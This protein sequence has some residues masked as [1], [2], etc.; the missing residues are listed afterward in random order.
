METMLPTIEIYVLALFLL[1]LAFL[2]YSR[3]ARVHLEDSDRLE[4]DRANLRLQ[5]I[6]RLLEAPD[7]RHLLKNRETRLYVFR[8]YAD[9]LRH[10]VWVLVRSGRLGFS[11]TVLAGLFFGVFYL[12]QAKALI[13]CGSTDLLLLG[14]L[15]LVIVRSLAA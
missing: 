12:L 8:E 6:V 11:S 2:A 9:A 7:T 4:L 13:H 15:E 14:R 1:F 3:L 10:D 5:T